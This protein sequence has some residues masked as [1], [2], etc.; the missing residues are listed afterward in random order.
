VLS[1][2][3]GAIATVASATIAAPRGA[4]ALRTF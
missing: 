3:R 2:W 4:A 1:G